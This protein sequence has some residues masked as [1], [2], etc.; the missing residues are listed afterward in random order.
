M[1]SDEAARVT[2]AVRMLIDNTK[3]YVIAILDEDSFDRVACVD[4]EESLYDNLKES[5]ISWTE[6]D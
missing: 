1:T 2:E 6:E 5:L 4:R 3:K